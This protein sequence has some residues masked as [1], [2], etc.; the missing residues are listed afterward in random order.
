VFGNALGD[1]SKYYGL[2]LHEMSH[3]LYFKHAPTTLIMNFP[4]LH[5]KDDVCIMSYDSNDGDH[6]GQCVASL[7]GMNE[8][9]DQLKTV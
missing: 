2:A 5:D 8:R 9:S 7:R 3:G 6:C 1:I 4:E